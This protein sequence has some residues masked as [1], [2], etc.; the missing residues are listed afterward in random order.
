MGENGTMPQV[1]RYRQLTLTLPGALAELLI[2]A[3]RYLV[4]DAIKNAQVA[5]EFSTFV[6]QVIRLGMD[7]LLATPEPDAPK[8]EDHGG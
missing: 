8:T 6:A 5:P 2:Q 1:R 4:A 3:H 7:T